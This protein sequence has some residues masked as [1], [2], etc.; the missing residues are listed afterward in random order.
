MKQQSQFSIETSNE[1][2]ERDLADIQRNQANPAPFA[3]FTWSGWLEVQ[4]RAANCFAQFI[5][6]VR[7]QQPERATMLGLEMQEVATSLLL[8]AHALTVADALALPHLAG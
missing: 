5:E 6:A 4:E 3:T 7:E 8:E 1:H 2:A